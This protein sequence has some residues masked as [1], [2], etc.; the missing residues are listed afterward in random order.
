[1]IQRK[2]YVLNWHLSTITVYVAGAFTHELS[3]A[4]AVQSQRDI[5]R[6][7]L[8]SLDRHKFELVAPTKD[9]AWVYEGYG[10]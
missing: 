2:R 3:F 6:H 4:A 10:I 1:M 9:G 5:V 8:R 7:L